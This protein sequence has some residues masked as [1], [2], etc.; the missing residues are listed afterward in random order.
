M[1]EKDVTRA[2]AAKPGLL[3]QRADTHEGKDRLHTRQAGGPVVLGVE[4]LAGA[5]YRRLLAP[6]GTTS[7]A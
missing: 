5:G 7:Q 3:R 6:D 2:P 1:T 4:G